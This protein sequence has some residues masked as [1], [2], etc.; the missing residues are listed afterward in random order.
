MQIFLCWDNKNFTKNDGVV[1][2]QHK[3]EKKDIALKCA[4]EWEGVHN[5]YASIAKI[6][7]KYRMYYRVGG[8]N[9]CVY[10]DETAQSKSMVCVA[11]S[12]DG[13]NFT[14]PTLNKFEFNGSKSN[15]VVFWRDNGGN[16]DTFTVFYDTNPD[17]KPEEQFK[18]FARDSGTDILDL[19]ISPDGYDFKF[20]QRI[21]L[22]GTFDSYNT[23]H[24]NKDTKQY[25]FYFRGYHHPDGTLVNGYADMDETNDLRDVRLAVSKDFRNWKFVDFIKFEN[26]VDVQLYT[27]QIRQYYREPNTLIGFPVRYIDR[28]NEQESFEYMPIADVR[29]RITQS[30]GRE[31]TA[32]TDCA[33]M[34]STDGLN[35]NLRP[36]AFFTPGME[37]TQNWWYGNCYT[38]YG[39]IETPT[40]DGENREISMYISENY[41]IKKVD[42][43]RYTLRL[44]GFFSWYGDGN[45][46]T[47]I[48]KPFI[49]ENENMF[50][51]F[52]TSAL[53]SLRIT[54]LSPDGKEIDGYKSYTI[55]GD[56][57]NRPV[58]FQN[59]LASLIGKEIQIKFE[60]E[61]CH[62]Y[63]YTFE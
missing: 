26:N 19:Y 52:A 15:N 29:N 25:H 63:S 21:E 1:V 6:G 47:A 28:V 30:A 17:C 50:V 22:G 14:K 53:G 32:L 31:G 38:V 59:S 45:G 43:R 11:E 18:A 10:K 42:F 23:V 2:L 9:G 39:M 20:A 13:I 49:L 44:D 16:L 40:D 8:Q 4:D 60:L 48:T 46:A 58:K 7:D 37:T 61:D 3:P 5:G 41:R 56:N 33:I 51:N 12:T 35:F 34:T 24:W 54:I 62:L 27:N 55:F 36:T 57:T